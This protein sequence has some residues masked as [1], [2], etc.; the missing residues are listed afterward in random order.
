MR[1][2]GDDLLSSSVD[3]GLVRDSS[4][5]RLDPQ[6]GTRQTSSPHQTLSARCETP[7][8]RTLHTAAPE[9]LARPSALHS[10]SCARS[11]RRSPSFRI[12]CRSNA[13]APGLEA[14]SSAS[15]TCAC[16]GSSSRVEEGNS[17]G[18]CTSSLGC[19]GS[20]SPLNRPIEPLKVSTNSFRPIS[21]LQLQ[22][23]LSPPTNRT[24]LSSPL[25]PLGVSLLLCFW[26]RQ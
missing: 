10:A 25:P 21:L 5:V 23:P 14:K 26:L 2:T 20:G 7:T 22:P 3:S 17:T 9:L 24:A 16:A 1:P 15:R 11:S 19:F 8:W 13:G 18:C 6:R 4:P 12:I